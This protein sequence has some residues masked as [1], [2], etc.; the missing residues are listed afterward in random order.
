[1]F[2]DQLVSEGTS[3]PI[4]LLSLICVDEEG[5]S[6]IMALLEQCERAEEGVRADGCGL[7]A[8]S[9]AEAVPTRSEGNQSP[10][11]AEGGPKQCVVP[12]SPPLCALPDL[13]HLY[14]SF[15]FTSSDQQTLSLVVCCVFSWPFWRE[16]A[17]LR[18]PRIL[19]H[20]VLVVF[21]SAARERLEVGRAQLHAPLVRARPPSNRPQ[22][23]RQRRLARRKPV[24][25]KEGRGEGGKGDGAAG[26][27]W[28]RRAGRSCVQL[29]S[30][31][32][33]AERQ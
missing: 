21:N 28:P 14:L 17:L 19:V 18:I 30:T 26:G 4:S 5:I 20:A 13:D 2:S 31:R 29:Y 23:R 27:R 8:W 3:A 7:G 24:D 16:T 9:W 1:M 32:K 15:S 10:R 6:I 25:A 11:R 12:M 22:R 33:G